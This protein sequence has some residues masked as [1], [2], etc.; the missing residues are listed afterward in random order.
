MKRNIIQQYLREIDNRKQGIQDN[1]SKDINDQCEI[2]SKR[3]VNNPLTFT[4]RAGNV[5]NLYGH[6]FTRPYD[7]T[8]DKFKKECKEFSNFVKEISDKHGLKIKESYYSFDSKLN[9]F[10]DIEVVKK[11]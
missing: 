7:S 10:C 1:I 3:D 11:T 9:W 4:A 2:Y 6:M 5:S 8:H